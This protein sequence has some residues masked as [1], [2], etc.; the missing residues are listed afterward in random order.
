LKKT[1]FV[2]STLRLSGP[3]QQLLNLCQFISKFGYEPQVLTLSPD[4]EDNLKESF[5]T[6][7]IQCC[8]LSLSRL[9]GIV[10]ARRHLMNAVHAFRPDVVHSQG[11][12]S[13][14][15]VQSLRINLPHILTV[16]NYPWDD[17]PK[18]FGK[19]RG[20]LMAYQH[21]KVIKHAR[22]PIAC[23]GSLAFRLSK[24][25]PNIKFVSNGV[26]TELFSPA[27]IKVK[28]QLKLSLGLSLEKKLI[29]CVGSLIPRKNPELLLNTYVNSDLFKSSDLF[30]LGD[31]FLRS[32]LEMLSQKR[33]EIKFPGKVNNMADYLKAADLLVS[34][35]HS[36]GLPNSVLEAL[37]CGVP[38]V[39]S[40]IEPHQEIKVEKNKAGKLFK[41]SEPQELIT[42]I[43]EVLDWDQNESSDNARKIVV[44]N[45]SAQQMAYRYTEH[46]ERISNI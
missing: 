2:V 6:A 37:A 38:V 13:D 43:K 10:S 42:S 18:A 4:P 22:L 8:S 19:I 30:F 28:N 7:K 45:F 15:L 5:D 40:D 12:R 11:I 16:R 14:Q 33:Q 36:E 9:G 1:L 20:G 35:S 17:Y 24:I 29:V 32:H 39:L 31:G 44:E 34:T 25:N 3:T 23:S 26:N 46:Y 21:L 27:S 41:L